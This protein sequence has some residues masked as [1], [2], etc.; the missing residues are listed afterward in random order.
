MKELGQRS[1]SLE[2]LRSTGT[3]PSGVFGLLLIESVPGEGRFKRSNSPERLRS[4]GQLPS[5]RGKINGHW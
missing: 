1:N 5:Q 3:L 4:M 2:G